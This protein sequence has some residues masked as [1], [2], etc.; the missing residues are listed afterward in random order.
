MP[1]VEREGSWPAG[2]SSRET[3]MPAAL[4]TCQ[5]L[6]QK[7]GAACETSRM[8]V[9]DLAGQGTRKRRAWGTGVDPGVKLGPGMGVGVENGPGRGVWVGVE[10]GGGVKVAVAPGRGV[11]VAV[12]PGGGVKVEV[13]PGGGEK[14]G[15]GTGE[16][17][18]VG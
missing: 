10:P 1:A 6:A 4:K 13:D 8:S 2:S 15:L 3:R 9:P 7:A 18:G 17:M 11:K 5:E 14:V 12:E 16:V